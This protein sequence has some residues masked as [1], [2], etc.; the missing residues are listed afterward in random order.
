MGTFLERQADGRLVDWQMGRRTQSGVV[1]CGFGFGLQGC[2]DAELVYL[3]RATFACWLAQVFLLLEP[4]VE[5]K[6]G[7][8]RAFS[9]ITHT[10]THIDVRKHTFASNKKVNEMHKNCKRN[11][12]LRPL[13]VIK[14]E[15]TYF[16]QRCVTGKQSKTNHNIQSLFCL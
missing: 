10:H 15:Y 11:Y 8:S 6:S 3:L 13:E 1:V 5:I 7:F 14:R 2:V 4:S 12:T 16:A 9:S